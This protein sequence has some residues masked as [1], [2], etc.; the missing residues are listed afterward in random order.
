MNGD[1]SRVTFNPFK[2]FTSIVLQQGRVQMDADGNEQTAILLHF[3]RSLASDLIGP[4]GGPDDLFTNQPDRQGLIQRNCGFGIVGNTGTN[5]NPV[6]VPTNIEVSPEEKTAFKNSP[7]NRVA[8]MITPGHYYV[9][10]LLC[11]NEAPWIYFDQPYLKSASDQKIK[12]LSGEFLVYL[13]V[14]ERHVTSV[15]DPSIREV[16]LGGADT[17]AR[18][19]LVWQVRIATDESFPNPAN[20]CGEFNAM[21]PQVFGLLKPANRGRLRA[22]AK[23]SDGSGEDN[24]CVTSPESRFRGI[25]NQL[26]R[27]EVH[28]GGPAMDNLG[29]NSE[30]AATIKWS[31]NNGT[32]VVPVKEKNGDRLVVSGLRDLS[33]WFEAGN[34]VEV[35]HDALELNGLPGT[36]VRLAKVEGEILTID[37]YTTSGTVY[38]PDDAFDGLPIRN[39]KVRLWDQKQPEDELLQDGAIPIEEEKWIDLE[40]GVRILFAAPVQNAPAT[41]YRTGDYWLIPARVATGDVEWPQE[42][43]NN[44][45]GPRAVRPHGVEH[46]YAPLASVTLAAGKPTAIVDFRHKFAPL[47]IC[48]A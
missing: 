35:T 18:T 43:V 24:V 39:L 34:W 38:E 17:A 25:E 6:F 23:G 28:R 21:W 10:G 2:H 36:L 37:P 11:E 5:D 44:E 3:L 14:W 13:D 32:T 9:D 27:V 7:N 29:S 31:R 30:S 20:T 26:Y 46:H 8:L 4:H 48:N 16:A 1:L 22:M 12:D 15:E 42:T 47:G 33:R 19:K 41:Q 45:T 40:D